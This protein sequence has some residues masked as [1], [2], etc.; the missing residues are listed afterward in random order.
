[1]GIVSSCYKVF[2]DNINADADG[3]FNAQIFAAADAG[4]L[5]AVELSDGVLASYGR[6]N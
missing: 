3:L 6:S 4:D 5:G 1:M 2:R